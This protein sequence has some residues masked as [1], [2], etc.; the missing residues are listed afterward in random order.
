MALGKHTLEKVQSGVS[1]QIASTFRCLVSLPPGAN[2]ESVSQL[3]PIT[4]PLP[5][6]GAPLLEGTAQGTTRPGSAP[7]LPLQRGL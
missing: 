3:S 7:S 5:H 6:P 4:Q 2:A 1:L